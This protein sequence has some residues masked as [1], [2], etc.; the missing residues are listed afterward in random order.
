[1]TLTYSR[2]RTRQPAQQHTILMLHCCRPRT[3]IIGAVGCDGQRPLPAVGSTTS[4]GG[5]VNLLFICCCLSVRPIFCELPTARQIHPQNR[6]HETNT[7][8][9]AQGGRKN[10]RYEAL[11]AIFVARCL[12]LAAYKRGEQVHTSQAI[13]VCLSFVQGD[14]SDAPKTDPQSHTAVGH[15]RPTAA[16]GAI[17]RGRCLLL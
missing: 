1:M 5:D 11:G 10:T 14:L 6:D 9:Q 15:G 13:C 2:Q 17:F 7:L 4:E 12:L 3:D 16:S 8:L